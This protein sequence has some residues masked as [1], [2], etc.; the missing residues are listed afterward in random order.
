MYQTQLFT[1]CMPAGYTPEGG[2]GEPGPPGL[3]GR[4][5]LQDPVHPAQ[6]RAEDRRWIYTQVGLNIVRKSHIHSKNCP[7]QSYNPFLHTVGLDNQ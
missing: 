6:H 4:G 3:Q 7:V 2:C 1:T 5:G